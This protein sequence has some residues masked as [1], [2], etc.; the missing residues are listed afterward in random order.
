MKKI[1]FLLCAVLLLLTA[2][3]GTTQKEP[4]ETLSVGLLPLTSSAPLFIGLEKG[5]FKEEGLDVEPV[6]FGAAQPITVAAASNTIDVGATGLTASLYNMAAAGRPVIITADKGREV[7]GYSSSVLIVRSDSPFF[8]LSDLKGRSFAMTTAGSSFEYMMGRMMNREG[9]TPEDIRFLPLRSLGSVMAAVKTGKADSAVV[10]EPNGTKAQRAGWA[11]IIASVGDSLPYQTSAVFYS[12][13]FAQ[14]HD[15]AVRFMKAYI[16]SCRWYY[17][18][19]LTAADRKSPDYLE[20]IA[21]I[22]RYTKAPPADIMNGLP[23]IDRDGRLMEEDIPSQIQ[24]Y[25]KEHLV[26]D[27]I[28]QIVNMSYWQEAERDLS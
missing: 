26:T 1:I 12:P 5:F 3:C 9:M 17:D 21:I 14:D 25:Q 11:R 20:G 22:A 13:A 8:R 10:N 18:H 4:K 16:R 27:N 15:R 24:W 6:W 2:G 7:P 19:V 23:W 28:P